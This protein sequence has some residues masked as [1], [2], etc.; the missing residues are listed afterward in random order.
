MPSGCARSLQEK[1]PGCE[2][3]GAAASDDRYR[4]IFRFRHQALLARSLNLDFNHP[5]T[6]P[7]RGLIQIKYYGT[8]LLY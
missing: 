4:D 5:D 2:G 8:K 7:K 6:W 1:I 3:A